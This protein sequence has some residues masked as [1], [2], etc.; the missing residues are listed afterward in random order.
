[1]GE[2]R[3]MRCFHDPGRGIM[4]YQGFVK[5]RKIKLGGAGS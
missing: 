1:M 3:K 2:R 4:Q 5:N